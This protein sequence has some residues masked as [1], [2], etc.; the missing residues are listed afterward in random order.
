MVIYVARDEFMAKRP[1]AT[2]WTSACPLPRVG[3]LKKMERCSKT[4]LVMSKIG[5]W[6]APIPI[7]NGVITTKHGLQQ[8]VYL[9]LFQPET[10]GVESAPTYRTYAL[11]IIVELSTYS[12]FK[13]LCVKIL[14]FWEDW[15]FE[16]IWIRNLY[17]GWFFKSSPSRHVFCQFCS[18]C[19]QCQPFIFSWGG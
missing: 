16:S 4:P 2:R 3:A 14:R 9:E 5:C 6:W 19:E 18:P 7:V 12:C 10:S 13:H 17:D 8:M 1:G 11:N 15:P